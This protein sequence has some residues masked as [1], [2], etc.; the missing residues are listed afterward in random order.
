MKRRIGAS[1]NAGFAPEFTAASAIINA[2]GIPTRWTDPPLTAIS[3]DQKRFS[4]RSDA[5]SESRILTVS[6]LRAAPATRGAL[7]SDILYIP[8]E[9]S[10]KPA[11]MPL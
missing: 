1:E 8:E 3:I 7:W 2:N 10:D 9:S 6:T 11:A 5:K 4:G